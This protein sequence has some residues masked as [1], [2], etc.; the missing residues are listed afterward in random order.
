VGEQGFN[1]SHRD[2]SRWKRTQLRFNRSWRIMDPH[3]SAD[4]NISVF[5]HISRR[6]EG[7]HHRQI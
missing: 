3:L 6:D 4:R 5:L 1:S 7:D 2:L